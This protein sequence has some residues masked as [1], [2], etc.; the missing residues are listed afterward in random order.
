[1]MRVA[2]RMAVPRAVVAMIVRMVM[3][4]RLIMLLRVRPRVLRFSTCHLFLD[5]RVART[6]ADAGGRAQAAPVS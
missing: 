6:F 4:V 5:P 2:V 1:M 3:I